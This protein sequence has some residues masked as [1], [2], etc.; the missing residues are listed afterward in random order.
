MGMISAV[1]C[2]ALYAFAAQ[3]KVSI[4]ADSS[5]SLSLTNGSSSS[6][7]YN[8]Q[9]YDSN[10]GSLLTLASQTLASKKEV[11]Y[12]GGKCGN[13]NVP[14]T[15]DSANTVVSCYASNATQMASACPG[16]TTICTYSELS[17]KTITGYGQM[18]VR[19]LPTN[20]FYYSYDTGTSWYPATNGFGARFTN[21]TYNQCDAD[22]DH[23]TGVFSKCNQAYGNY[24]NVACC[25]TAGYVENISNCDVTVTSPSGH[26]QS[27]T[28]K[29]GSPF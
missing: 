14:S 4:L 2:V 16:G 22:A 21:A 23:G 7:T 1:M 26:L 28:F 3:R 29:G 11:K 17:A 13:G 5:K 12:G 18:V 6:V 15:Y 8:I 25:K 27:P 10:G 20:S 24:G 9:C 19:G